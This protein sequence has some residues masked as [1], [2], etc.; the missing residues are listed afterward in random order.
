MRR[1]RLFCPIRNT[2]RNSLRGSFSTRIHVTSI[3]KHK[4][5]A[6]YHACIGKRGVNRLIEKLAVINR[7]SGEL[8]CRFVTDT[9]TISD[10][11]I[12]MNGNTCFL[13]N[14]IMYVYIWD[15]A[16]ETA[17]SVD[18]TGVQKHIVTLLKSDKLKTVTISPK[19]S[20]VLYIETNEGVMLPPNLEISVAENNQGY[21][22][23]ENKGEE[24]KGFIISAKL[25]EKKEQD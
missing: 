1:T 2:L 6:E 14:A 15:L 5:S 25:I 24:I 21:C 7:K 17:G 8:D 11:P 9:G 18:T 10:M 22:A 13:N 16:P 19:D 3:Y 4:Q 23:F 12:V 20:I